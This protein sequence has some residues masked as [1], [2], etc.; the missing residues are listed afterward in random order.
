MSETV[1]PLTVCVACGKNVEEPNRAAKELP[2]CVACGKAPPWENS[3]IMKM[4]QAFAKRLKQ[5]KDG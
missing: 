4:W 3:E 2:T 5:R 1:V